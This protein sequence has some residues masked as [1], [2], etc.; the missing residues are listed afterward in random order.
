MKKEEA[1]EIAKKIDASRIVG[2]MRLANDPEEENKKEKT[3]QIDIK[4]N[5]IDYKYKVPNIDYFKWRDRQWH[6]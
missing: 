4:L 1:K 3:K 5:W 6:F 2:Y